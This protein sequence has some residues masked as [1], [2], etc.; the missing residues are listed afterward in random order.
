MATA[1]PVT[2]LHT[3]PSAGRTSSKN[4]RS[5]PDRCWYENTATRGDNT[6]SPMLVSAASMEILSPGTPSTGPLKS[7]FK[8]SASSRKRICFPGNEYNMSDAITRSTAPGAAH[9]SFEGSSS[10]PHGRA[11]TVTSMAPRNILPCG[12]G[13][14]AG[15]VDIEDAVGGGKAKASTASRLR[16]TF[17]RAKG[18]CEGR[19]VATTRCPQ[20]AAAREGRGQPPQPSSRQTN[21]CFDVLCRAGDHLSKI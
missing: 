4:R 16:S 10:P 3:K 19:S 7:C 17:T 8:V 15:E 2:S 13:E 18:S 12:G 6:R 9:Q 14:G 5:S 21:G 1:T 11:V 20:R